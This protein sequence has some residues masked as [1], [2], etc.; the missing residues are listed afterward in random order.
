MRVRQESAPTSRSKL[1]DDACTLVDVLVQSSPNRSNIRV[2][3]LVQ[4]RSLMRM[5]AYLG[6]VRA[7]TRWFFTSVEVGFPTVSITNFL[8]FPVDGVT[9]C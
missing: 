3:K 7:D 6:F 1:P 8:T 4:P 5:A 2:R 9:H